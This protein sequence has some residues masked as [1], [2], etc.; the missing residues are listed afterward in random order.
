MATATTDHNM[1]ETDMRTNGPVGTIENVES[2]APTVAAD[3]SICPTQT[4]DKNSAMNDS[5]TTPVSGTALTHNSSPSSTSSPAQIIDETTDRSS[6]VPTLSGQ[7]THSQRACTQC[8]RHKIKCATDGSGSCIRCRKKGFLCRIAPRKKRVSRKA[9]ENELTASVRL[10]HNSDDDGHSVDSPYG[11]NTAESHGAQ[12]LADFAN[13]CAVASTSAALGQN[14]AHPSPAESVLAAN[15][16]SN[17]TRQALPLQPSSANGLL[18]A[19][20]AARTARVAEHM[21]Q[22]TISSGDHYSVYLSLSFAYP[23]LFRRMVDID[24]QHNSAGFVPLTSN[25]PLFHS[26]VDSPAFP[27]YALTFQNDPDM[28]ARTVMPISDEAVQLVALW[29]SKYGEMLLDIYFNLINPVQPIIHRRHFMAAYNANA[30]STVLLLAIFVAALPYCSMGT[31]EDR[32][33]LQTT[34]LHHLYAHYGA[35]L[36]MPTF[37]AVQALSLIADA[38]YDRGVLMPHSAAVSAAIELR[39]HVDCSEWDIPGWE[40]ALRK[41][42]WWSLCIRDAWSVTRFVGTPKILAEYFDTPV[43]TAAE[44]SQLT[45]HES[46]DLSLATLVCTVNVNG[47]RINV[48]MESCLRSFIS[49]ANLSEILLEINRALYQAKGLRLTRQQPAAA[50]SHIAETLEGKLQELLASWTREINDSGQEE[51]EPDLYR[52]MMFY[53]VR[54]SLYCQFLPHRQTSIRLDRFMLDY[55]TRFLD[56]IQGALDALKRFKKVKFSNY[57]PSWMS[58][59]IILNVFVLLDVCIAKIATYIKVNNSQKRKTGQPNVAA[60]GVGTESSKPSAPPLQQEQRRS[61]ILE[62]LNKDR[63]SSRV[64]QYAHEGINTVRE[65]GATWEQPQEIFKVLLK[66]TKSFGLGDVIEFPMCDQMETEGAKQRQQYAPHPLARPEAMNVMPDM[67]VVSEQARDQQRPGIMVVENSQSDAIPISQASSGPQSAVGGYDS[68]LRTVLPPHNMG[69]LLSPMNPTQTQPISQERLPLQAQAQQHAA[70]YPNSDVIPQQQAF[71]GP[72]G[73]RMQ[74]ELYED[75]SSNAYNVMNNTQNPQNMG[76]F[77]DFFAHLSVN[78]FEG[79][80]DF[81]RDF[82]L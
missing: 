53:F 15:S 38:A 63:Y 26:L 76:L 55:Y 27:V 67:H 9:K 74:Q 52:Y 66:M 73:G 31:L 43:P 78:L 36:T 71:V 11:L 51:M 21:M 69:M 79:I 2:A 68:G 48:S 61:L 1:K 35:K 7:I 80:S 65:L 77:D 64:V 6:K 3:T 29:K 47:S 60:R 19:A 23:E 58:H 25:R 14:L 8:Q 39:L 5:S 42:L 46:D 81:H 12:K 59:V 34:F 72:F 49:I 10:D 45:M 32:R 57:W 4:A 75:P 18:A 22:S 40:R 16:V 33:Q 41:A 82:V 24:S 37:D 30:E 20:G 44:L 28:F 50:A 56:S 62:F 13:V 54:V 17:T 70:Y